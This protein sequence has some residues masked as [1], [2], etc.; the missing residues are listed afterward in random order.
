MECSVECWNAVLTFL[1]SCISNSTKEHTISLISDYYCEEEIKSSKQLLC[2]KFDKA[3]KVRKTTSGRSQKTA[4]S[5]DMYDM[6]I[7]LEQDG[8][9][10]TETFVVDAIGL[11]RIPRIRPEDITYVSVASKLAELESKV[12]A[13]N[14]VVSKIDNSQFINKLKDS[15]IKNTVETDKKIKQVQCNES[16]FITLKDIS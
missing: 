11:M 4:H 15:P 9:I 2:D 6:L 14:N 12:S 10:S 1:M 5:L 13:M 3:F 16:S 7:E 8:K